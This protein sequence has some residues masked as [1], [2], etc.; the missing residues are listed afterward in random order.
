MTHPA[1][2]KT[3]N[4]A[5]VALVALSHLGISHAGVDAAQAKALATR[6]ACLG[7]HAVSMRLVGPGYAEV[8]AKYKGT[9]ASVLAAR[10]QSGGTGK[11]GTLQM[12][13]QPTLSQADALLLA[14]W[15]L[16]GAP[17]K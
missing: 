14:E 11:W 9:E 15:V 1:P 3:L 6:N 5:L 17:D 10:I 16:A 13:A 12:P 2:M 8:A 7:C 4:P